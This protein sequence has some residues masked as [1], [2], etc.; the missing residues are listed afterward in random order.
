MYD[1]TDI[2]SSVIPADAQI[3][4]GYIDGKYLSYPDMVTRF[5]AA[6]HVAIAVFASDELGDVLDVET[7]DATP[8]QAPAWIKARRA[9]GY[10]RPTV[11]CPLSSANA[12]VWAC[13][14]AGLSQGVDFDLWVAHYDGSPA[15]A[16]AGEVAKQYL[17]HGPNGENYDVSAVY[18]DAWPHRALTPIPAPQEADDMAFVISTDGQPGQYLL[19]GSLV[20]ALD[21]PQSVQAFLDAGAKPAKVSTA[22]FSRIASHAV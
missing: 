11:Y 20:L 9:A 14:R 12:V 2:P 15:P 18:D 17:N 7:G 3:V 13:N 21:D 19:N 10:R 5:P 6:T 1:T 8:A 16:G 22:E 4:A